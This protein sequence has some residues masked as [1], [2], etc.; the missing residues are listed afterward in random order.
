VR[1]RFTPRDGDWTIDDVLV[2]PY[3]TR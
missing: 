2:D 1:L 3:R